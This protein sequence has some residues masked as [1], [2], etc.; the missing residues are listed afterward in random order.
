[1]KK[2][3]SQQLSSCIKAILLLTLC[4]IITGSGI[5]A[6]ESA[7]AAKPVVK[8][9]SYVKN[10]FGG[11]FLID[12]QTVMVPIKGTFEFDINHRFGT[13]DK[14]MKDLFGIFGTANMRLGFS[15]VP[16]KDLQVGFGVGNYNMIV[17]VNLK[18]AL[19][20]QT[21]NND[22]PVSV[23]YYGSAAM[24]TRIKNASLP[25]VSTSDRFSYF[26]TL[27]V[28]RKISEAFSAQA[29]FNY[30]HFNNVEGY[31]DKDNVIQPTMK[32][33]HLSFSL[34]GRYKIS[35]KTAIIVNYDQPITQHPTNNP[36]PNLCIG[37]DMNSS[38]HGFQVFAG[39]YSYSLPQY[40]H[41]FNQNDYQAGQFVIGFNISRLWNF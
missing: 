21:M 39:N 6:Q 9:V 41:M 23:T 22:V 32:N 31:Y 16:V 35:P 33:D 10:T 3:N 26:N 38:G 2:R 18:Y 15:Y 34:S 24:D 4:I 25:I 1:M 29:A 40:N 11:N 27:M 36:R 14:G 17:D 8:K 12:N 30:T 7:E 28:A 19:L 20:K 37:L 13:T 5:R